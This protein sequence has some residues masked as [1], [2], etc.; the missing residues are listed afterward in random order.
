M[1]R[2]GALLFAALTACALTGNAFADVIS[3]GQ[4]LVETGILPVFLVIL[5]VVFTALAIRK[6]KK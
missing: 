2:F 1:K 6:K 4:F 3:P 5:V